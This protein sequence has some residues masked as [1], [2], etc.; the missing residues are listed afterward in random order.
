[1]NALQYVALLFKR[2][3]PMMRRALGM[4][5]VG[6]V[7]ILVAAAPCSPVGAPDV[8]L[9]GKWSCDDDGTYFVRQVGNKICWMGK[10]KEG[11]KE[12]TN[13]FHGEIKGRQ[14]IGDWADVPKGG[15]MG[16]GTMHLEL[17]IRRGNVVEIRKTK[18]IGDNFGGGV[19]KRE[20]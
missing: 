11:G 12:W 8:D 16:S 7:L 5:T 1:M 10:S 19:W 17:E 15:S 9:T 3:N 20:G 6:L 13:V 4:I 18:Q 2:R 14:I